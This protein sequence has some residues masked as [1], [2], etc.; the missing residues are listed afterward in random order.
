MFHSK[1]KTWSIVNNI[2]TCGTGNSN[3]EEKSN[4]KKGTLGRP[5]EVVGK[6]QRGYFCKAINKEERVEI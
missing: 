1:L 6:C 4:Q 3:R 2:F 5:R